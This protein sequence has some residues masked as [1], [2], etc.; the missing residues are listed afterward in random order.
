MDPDSN[1]DDDIFVIDLKDAT[2]QKSFS[3]AFLK[4]QLHHFSK[5]K[6][7]KEITKH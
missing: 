6:S 1:P 2:K 7:S 3:K 4:V 5:V